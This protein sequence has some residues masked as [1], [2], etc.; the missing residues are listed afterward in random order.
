[1]VAEPISVLSV[2]NKMPTRNSKIQFS[3][4]IPTLNEEG[5]L[6]NLLADLS[7]QDYRG[8]EVIVVDAKSKDKTVLTAK[9]YQKKLPS[10]KILQSSRP[11]VSLQRNMGAKEAKG[12]W[13]IFMDAD[14]RIPLFFLTGVR[15]RTIKDNPD[16]FTCW[17]KTEEKSS[18]DKAIEIFINLSL[19]TLKLLDYPAALGAL[20]GVKSRLFGKIGGFN[21]KTK[22]AEDRDFIG[23]S[24]KKGFKFRV[25]R[26]PYYIYSFRRFK[27]EG[28]MQALRNYVRINLKKLMKLKIKQGKDY[29]MGG[30]YFDN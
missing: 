10:I 24:F 13:I 20:I 25:F 5:F 15:Y 2:R 29:P 16:V 28:K 3:I 12:K 1:M 21:V 17:C 6:P 4:V 9:E 26:D 14:N 19:E 7:R 23:E 11:N 18:E 22:F 8:F 30:S 27:K